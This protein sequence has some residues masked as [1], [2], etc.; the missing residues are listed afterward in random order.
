MKSFIEVA[1]E[2]HFPIQNLPFGIFKPADGTAR[3]G[4]AIGDLVLDLSVLEKRG[5]FNF[6]ELQD[7]SVFSEGALNSFL[8]LG[9]PAWRKTRE[10]IQRLLDAQPPTLR[11]AGELRPRPFYSHTEVTI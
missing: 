6:P 3:V 11:D 8:S 5:H 2:S 4:V 10:V 9:R 7:R 1:A